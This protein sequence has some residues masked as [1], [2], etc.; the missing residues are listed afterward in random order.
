[1]PGA[2][3]STNRL[4]KKRTSTPKANFQTKHPTLPSLFVNAHTELFDFIDV[5]QIRL[6]RHRCCRQGNK[7]RRII[8]NPSIWKRSSLPAAAPNIRC[9]PFS[10]RKLQRTPRAEI[11]NR[12]SRLAVTTSVS[13]L[14]GHR[15]SMPMS[16][17]PP[18]GTP[19]AE[20][21]SP[22]RLAKESR[23]R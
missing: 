7:H 22:D 5:G 18:P 21:S 9:T 10:R 23:S 2:R 4:R 11:N 20:V 17:P 19:L 8:H 15:M 6:Q 13:N 1:M 16:L 14:M 3:S 12:P